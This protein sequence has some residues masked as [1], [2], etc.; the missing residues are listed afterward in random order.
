MLEETLMFLS[1]DRFE[2]TFTQK[3]EPEAER[4]RFFNFDSESAWQAS[5][6]LMFSG[7]LDSF[8]GA[9]EE[10]AEQGQRVALVSHFSATKIAPVQRNLQKTLT[11]K[12][13]SD[14]CRHLP[15][16]VQMT[17][18][19]LKEGTHRSRS[20]LFATLG[21]ITAQAFN[22]DRVSF[23]ENGVVSLN[24]PPVGSVLGT[25]ATRT[26]HPQSLARFTGF[27]QQVFNHRFRIDNPFF[28]RTKKD[29]VET[30]SRL[31]MKDQIP[32]TRSC[33]DV[34]NQTKLYAHCGRCSQCID[35]RFAVMSAGLEAFDP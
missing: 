31:G 10:I 27:F 28:W 18:R 1:G 2:F 21:A 33:A 4:T 7:G 22:L 6:V 12:F 25:R 13:G 14:S 3:E 32:H 35:R 15:V 9:L 34:H 29:V 23:Y 19:G 16:Q 24:L 8:A 30:I 11:G 26:T 5:R 17:G 20:F